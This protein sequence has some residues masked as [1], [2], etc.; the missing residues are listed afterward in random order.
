MYTYSMSKKTL[1]YVFL[2]FLFAILLFI[3]GVRYGQRVEQVNK[4]IDYIVKMPPSPT[5]Q[6]TVRPVAFTVYSH[7]G[8]SLSFLV[9]NSLEKTNES[10]NSAVFAGVDKK[11]EIALSCEKTPF[12][13]SNSER[14]INLNK[15]IR[16]FEKET[17]DTHSYRFYHS[18]TGKVIT[19]TVTKQYLPLIQK[20]LE[21]ISK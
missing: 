17:K 12:I 3:L 18:I 7:K 16:S 5:P 15:T 13:Q 14:I 9:P 2:A 1:P 4:T 8:C 10:S 19:L 20:S 6:P 21:F 11:L